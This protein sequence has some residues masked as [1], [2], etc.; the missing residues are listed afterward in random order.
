VQ[1]DNENGNAVCTTADGQLGVY[2]R[3]TLRVIATGEI[4][5]TYFRCI[6]G[7]PAPPATPPAA[8][9]REELRKSVPVPEPSIAANPSGQGVT[10]LDS[11][12]WANQAGP[13]TAT[14]TLRGWTVTGTLTPTKWVWATGDGASYTASTPGSEADPAVKHAYQ[15]KGSRQLT[16]DVS[17]EGSYAVSGYGTAYTV[18]DLATEST[19]A[20]DYPVAEIRSVL[21]D[22][23]VRQP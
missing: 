19:A 7:G 5:D 22:P 18:E 9:T 15:T 14:V 23:A 10:G 12:F 2:Y 4:L 13:V 6:P 11:W 16:V 3:F 21:D 17:W 8:P 1:G 20:V